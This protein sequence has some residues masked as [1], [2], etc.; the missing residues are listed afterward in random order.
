MFGFIARGGFLFGPWSSPEFGWSGGGGRRVVVA[1]GGVCMAD[2]PGREHRSLNGNRAG[3]KVQRS[4]TERVPVSGRGRGRGGVLVRPIQETHTPKGVDC[5]LAPNPFSATR[6]RCW[7]RRGP[8]AQNPHPLHS[9]LTA[10]S[11]GSDHVSSDQ[12]CGLRPNLL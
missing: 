9:F 6:P 7:L 2:C 3:G 8:G 5:T 10:S 4:E 11:L 1:G 12:E